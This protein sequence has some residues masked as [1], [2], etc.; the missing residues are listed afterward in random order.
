MQVVSTASSSQSQNN[1]DDDTP[2]TAATPEQIELLSKPKGFILI[3]SGEAG[4]V[5]VVD[6]TLPEQRPIQSTRIAVGGSPG[7]AY[8][9]HNRNQVH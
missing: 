8:A 6:T 3:N 1:L 7:N 4:E 5:L 2:L 9:V